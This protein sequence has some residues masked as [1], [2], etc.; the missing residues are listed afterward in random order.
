MGLPV[1]STVFNGA[2]EIMTDGTHGYVL[3]DPFDVEALAA[4]M[5][6]LMDPARREQMSR[7]CLE[8]RPRLAYAHHLEQLLAVYRGLRRERPGAAVR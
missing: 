2:C 4:A 6:K 3:R 5:R 8:L 1:V 7:A